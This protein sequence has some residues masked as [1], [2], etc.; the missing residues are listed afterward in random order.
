[1][2]YHARVLDGRAVFVT[3]VGTIFGQR[4]AV[5]FGE[6]G[7]DVA[8]T[9]AAF[10]DRAGAERALAGTRRLDVVVHVAVDDAAL[11][12]APLVDT[13][14]AAWDERGEA[15]LRD[16]LFTFQAAHDRF[17]AAGTGRIVVVAP[18]SGF[19]GAAGFVPYSTAVEGIRALAKSA[20]RAWAADGITVNTVLVPPA[21]VAPALV[22]AT[23][24][25]AP[26]VIGR[27]PDL[28][29]DVAA[30]IAHFA[31]PTSGGITG[32]TTIVDG[33]TVMAP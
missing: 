4:L 11:D 26:P 31:A 2:A 9:A 18:T 30:T 12:A 20:A 3:H 1:M 28:R 15:F 29:H 24:F 32:A 22:D 14:P 23:A 27:L 13:P 25:E 6:H 10:P 17:V 19:T 21:L 5:T 7:A 16:A 33:G 8:T